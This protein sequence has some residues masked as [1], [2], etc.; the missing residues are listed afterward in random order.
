MFQFS[1][2]NLLVCESGGMEGHYIGTRLCGGMTDLSKV[3]R[4]VQSF[5]YLVEDL[6][7]RIDYIWQ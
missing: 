5:K 7:T 4:L 6:A 3:F 2:V 1:G